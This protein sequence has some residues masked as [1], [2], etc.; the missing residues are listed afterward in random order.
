MVCPSSDS[1]ERRLS[2]VDGGPS[3]EIESGPST[4]PIQELLPDEVSAEALH[5]SEQEDVEEESECDENDEA[6]ASVSE[7]EIENIRPDVDAMCLEQAC[8]GVLGSFNSDLWQWS[9]QY[10]V[11]IDILASMVEDWVMYQ[12]HGLPPRPAEFYTEDTRRWPEF[13]LGRRERRLI[14][15]KEYLADKFKRP[16]FLIWET[17]IAGFNF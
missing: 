13:S 10:A 2:I 11:P 14:V 9:R 12:L 4:P 6:W 1:S 15:E 17:N 8:R 16:T 3:L 7:D 5:K